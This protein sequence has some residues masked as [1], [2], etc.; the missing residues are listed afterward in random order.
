MNF[1]G[2]FKRILTIKLSVLVA[3]FI[4]YS[5]YLRG[6]RNTVI[7][8][9]PLSSTSPVQA[10]NKDTYGKI[11][12][13]VAVIT[14]T[15]YT[16]RVIP[17]ILHFHSVLGPEW[18]IIFFTSAETRAQ[19]FTWNPESG[20]KTGSAIW[21]RAVEDGTVEVR[22]L[23]DEV[24]VTTRLGVNLYF[25]RPWFWEQLA[26][27]EHVLLFQADS[28]ICANAHRT[29]DSF[30]PSTFIGA[31]LSRDTQPKKFN[32][33]LSLRN[34]PLILSI[35]SSLPLNATWEAETLAKSYAHGEDSW[36]SREMERRGVKL[37]NRQEALQFACQGDEHL[38]TWPEP[39]G[40]HKVH[41]MI[42]KRLPEIRR[43]CPEIS[44]AGA[45]MFGNGGGV[46]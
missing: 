18:P 41:V 1:A 23:P 2:S 3:L 33:G 25:T 14:D 4:F 29:I 37:P 30:L 11:Q 42:P 9:A 19:H 27:A 15:H 26:P 17:L 46:G 16:P 35:L 7:S 12:S 32:G 31:P 20:N 10:T 40:F 21:Q 38:D 43:W 28:M 34:R 8:H 13:K 39:L 44:L 6:S 45:G 5:L 24:D 22:T 36:F